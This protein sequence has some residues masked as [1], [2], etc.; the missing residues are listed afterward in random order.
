[1]SYQEDQDRLD[2]LAYCDEYAEYII[3][4]AG[5]NRLICNGDGLTNAMEEG[6]LFEEFL[7][8]IGESYLLDPEIGDGMTDV[9]ADADALRNIGWG[10]DEDYGGFDDRY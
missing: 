5:S 7:A 1:M 6:Y 4:N 8:S 3:C 9:E 2:E 10:T